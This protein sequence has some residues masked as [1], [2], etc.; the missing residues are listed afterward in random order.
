M[1]NVDLIKLI[2]NQKANFTLDQAF[3]ADDYIFDLDV[4]NLFFNIIVNN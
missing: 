3:Y 1:N 2:K 4:K